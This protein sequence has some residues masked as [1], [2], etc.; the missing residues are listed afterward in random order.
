MDIKF[1]LLLISISLIIIGYV[2][3]N[4]YNC[5]LSQRKVNIK[6]MQNIIPDSNSGLYRLL[7]NNLKSDGNKP[8][9][10][11]IHMDTPI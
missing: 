2:N 8:K 1:I 9:T 3:Q 5:N 7:L 11:P 10:T 6:N 4:T